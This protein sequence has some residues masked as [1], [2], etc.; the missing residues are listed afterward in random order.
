MLAVGLPG[1]EAAFYFS[2]SVLGVPRQEP[3]TLT[4]TVTN[5]PRVS[6]NTF[7]SACFF[8]FLLP[9]SIS[10]ILSKTY[11]TKEFT[12]I[13][14]PSCWLQIFKKRISSM[15]CAFEDYCVFFINAKKQTACCSWLLPLFPRSQCCLPA[16][17]SFG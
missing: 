17:R 15:L 16:A 13:I 12:E 4:F 6:Q 14:L 9:S 5:A 2:N 3:H 11:L 8:I 10:N 7:H 1:S